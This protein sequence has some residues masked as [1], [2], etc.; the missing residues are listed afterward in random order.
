MSEIL[1]WIV[2][3]FCLAGALGYLLY[4]LGLFE[5][6]G[7]MNK[8]RGGHCSACPRCPTEQTVSRLAERK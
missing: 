4:R 7:W 1:Q 2:V 6:L 3:G 5:L 8:R